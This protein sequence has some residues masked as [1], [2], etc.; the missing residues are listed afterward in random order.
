MTTIEEYVNNLPQEQL[1]NY[2]INR[3]TEE[4][5]DIKNYIQIIN[6]N[7]IYPDERSVNSFKKKYLKLKEKLKNLVE[8]KFDNCYNKALEGKLTLEDLDNVRIK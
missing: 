7:I 6:D 1:K 4:I 5:K 3:I 8:T 2:A